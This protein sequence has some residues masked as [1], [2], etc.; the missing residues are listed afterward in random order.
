MPARRTPVNGANTDAGLWRRLRD[1][2]LRG[3]PDRTG[4]WALFIAATRPA[5]LAGLNDLLAADGL[6]E[7]GAAC[8]GPCHPYR[9]LHALTAA[10]PR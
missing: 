8:T 1:A 10:E 6:L 2:R 3:G 4:D 9:L 7:H 5:Y